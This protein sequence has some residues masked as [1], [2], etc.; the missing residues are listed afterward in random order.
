LAGDKYYPVLE[1]K[2]IVTFDEIRP[3]PPKAPAR[4]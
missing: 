4:P 3:S 1:G 2:G